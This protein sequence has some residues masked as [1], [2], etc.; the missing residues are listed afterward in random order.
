[1]SARLTERISEDMKTALRARDKRR[2]GAIRLMLAAIR[3]REVDT[4]ATLDDPQ[5]L[6]ILDKMVKQ[7][8]ESIVQY[9]AAARDDLA[10][11][12]RFELDVIQ[13][14]LPSPLSD[15]DIERLIEAAV[16]ET[17]ANNLRDMGKVMAQLKPQVLGRADLATISAK[18]K[19]RLSSR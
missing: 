3:Q 18:V 9:D 8:R 13:G 14:Y 19:T 4:R 10:A 1:M 12:E 7:R 5:V 16:A 2:L 11:V 15:A 6:A 17:G